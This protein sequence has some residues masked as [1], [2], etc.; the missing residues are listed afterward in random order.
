LIGILQGLLEW[1]PISSQGNITML[2][3]SILGLEPAQALSLAIY[4]HVGTGLAA[5]IYFRRDVLG[6]IRRGNEGDPRLLRFLM[7]STLTTGVVG[8]PI[9]LLA[10]GVS[11]YGEALLALTGAALLITGL[12]QRG[13]RQIG[14]RTASSLR[15]KEG[16]MMGVAQ[17]LSAIP[18]LS[19]SGVTSS[20]LLIRG[21]SGDEAFR[22]SF[23]MAIPASFAAALGLAFVEG[24]PPLEPLF[25]VSL[26]SSFFSALLSIG[27]LLR[28]ARRV[29]FW[30]L[31][32]LLGA[33][34]LLSPLLRLL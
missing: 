16:F 29:R 24:V 5:L 19:R 15:D 1:L 12:V 22:V 25:L 6:M 7:I 3:I 4:L 27:A 21:L 23:L 20:V 8:L 33:L 18:G 30:G 10:R 13:A 9:F 17:G 2:M 11:A 28:L 34:A 32:V 14:E 26:A 31:C